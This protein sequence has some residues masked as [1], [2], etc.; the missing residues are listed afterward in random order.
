MNSENIHDKFFKS[1]MTEKENAIDFFQNY[2][3]PEL[4][5]EID[6]ET[7]ELE[8]ESFVD[9]K[10]KEGFSDVLYRVKIHQKNGYLYTLFDH[11]SRPGKYTALQLLKYILSIWE[12]HL[13]LNKNRGKLPIVLPIVLYH[14]KSR[15]RS[16]TSLK[17]IIEHLPAYESYIPDF[18]YRLYDLSKY[19]D[20][21]I[22]G[23]VI[24]QTAFHL[25]KNIFSSELEERLPRIFKLFEKLQD[26]SRALRWIEITMRYLVRSSTEITLDSLK[27]VAENINLEG[28]S[29]NTMP[30]IAETLIK[31]GYEKGIAE[32][33][34][35]ADLQTKRAERKGKLRT[36]INLKKAGAELA[37]IAKITEFDEVYL[38]RFFC[39]LGEEF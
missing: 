20:E 19:S 3:P 35:L 33:K 24:L 30:T 5:K 21:E 9:D 31:E 27:K 14:G 28:V 26:E 39:R 18:Q 13:K 34:R 10:L 29:K 16:G 15:W 11:K 32:A 37:F 25:L 7:L 2:L 8:K 23:N 36:A 6:L 1:L 38:N 12:R 17:P 22:K 4:L